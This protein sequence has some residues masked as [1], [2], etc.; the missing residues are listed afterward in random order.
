MFSS[1]LPPL[2]PQ[3]ELFIK[4]RSKPNFP[5]FGDRPVSE[6][7]DGHQ[8]WERP[9]RA[10]GRSV[11]VWDSHC[12][13]MPGGVGCWMLSRGWGTPAIIP[14]SS[15]E[16]ALKPHQRRRRTEAGSAGEVM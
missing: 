12:G 6:L 13:R 15:D 14:I 10:T 1:G 9:V 3:L 16:A 7:T 2:D 11:T 8:M 5:R 4:E